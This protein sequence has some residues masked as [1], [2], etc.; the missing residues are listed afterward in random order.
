MEMVHQ[1]Q[2]WVG[3]SPAPQ[4]EE[5]AEDPSSCRHEDVQGGLPRSVATPEP[6]V[7]NTP[8][9]CPRSGGLQPARQ[10][11]SEPQDG[12]MGKKRRLALTGLVDQGTPGLWLGSSAT[13]IRL[14]SRA[15]RDQL[16]LVGEEVGPKD[17]RWVRIVEDRGRQVALLVGPYA[18]RL[19]DAR[20]LSPGVPVRMR[21]RVRERDGELE[22][23]VVPYG[24]PFSIGG[25][26]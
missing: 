11:P 6:V 16:L 25:G 15:P 21:R 9:T 7:G 8:A 18:R 23:E 24:Q 5:E 19:L 26:R 10:V 13:G 4:S 2:L 12:R 14:S 17:P 22:I 3:E 1:P 20:G